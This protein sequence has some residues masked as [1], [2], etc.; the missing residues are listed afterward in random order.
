MVRVLKVNKFV[1]DVV[2]YV[3]MV[4]SSSFMDLVYNSKNYMN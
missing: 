1:I 4:I 2:V 3:D